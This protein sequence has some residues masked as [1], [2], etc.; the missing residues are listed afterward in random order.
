LHGE[1]SIPAPLAALSLGG[2]WNSEVVP[3][4][5]TGLLGWL[6]VVLV[7]A[8]FAL[9]FRR[10]RAGGGRRDLLGFGWCWA[11]GW[12]L[13]V[14]TWLAPTP[15]G[16]L[17]VHVPGVGLLRDG[18]R[19]LSL[20]ALG[21]A[22]VAGYAASSMLRRLPEAAHPGMVLALLLTPVA[23]L[24]GAAWGVSGRLRP[25]DFPADYSAARSVIE[26]QADSGAQ[27]DVLVL[28]LTSYRQPDWNHGHKVLDPLGRYQSLDYVAG[29]DLFV[30]GA[31][32]AGEDRRVHDVASA[33]RDP[34]PRDRAS[35]LARL[36]IGFVV[37]E[38]D[39]GPSPEVAGSSILD[40]PALSV[41]ALSR[42]AERRVPWSWV[43]AMAGAWSLFLVPPGASAL[44]AVRRRMSR[45]APK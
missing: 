41:Q 42:S 21:L 12:G 34:D 7:V 43:V 17:F 4:S 10:W 30:D 16:W 29:D 3:S 18:S 11:V 13:A 33:L 40:R 5:R 15:M 20:C 44:V 36:G 27:G 9:G 24:P 38:K 8:L 19:L 22:A 26:K 23:L 2:I 25:A 28:P 39:A 31:R 1:G 45:R 32:V 14:L 6:S 35:R 37:T